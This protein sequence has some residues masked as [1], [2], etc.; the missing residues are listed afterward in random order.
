MAIVFHSDSRS[1]LFVDC[2]A[3]YIPGKL[4]YNIFSNWSISDPLAT[5]A[6]LIRG[7]RV[8]IREHPGFSNRLIDV[9]NVRQNHNNNYP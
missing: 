4:K 7:Y 3:E 8:R 5:E 6:A 1:K 9:T 2:F